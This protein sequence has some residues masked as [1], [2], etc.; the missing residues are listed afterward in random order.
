MYPEQKTGRKLRAAMSIAAAL[1]VL[2]LASIVWLHG[3]IVSSADIG[4]SDARAVNFVGK[5]VNDR[6][7]A[8]DTGVPSAESVFRGKG[9]IA[10]EEPIT[11]D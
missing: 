8:S 9:Y 7:T 10:P 11:Q 5:D 3:S 6:A 1:C 2:G 4:M